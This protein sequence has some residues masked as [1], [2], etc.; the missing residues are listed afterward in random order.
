MSTSAIVLGCIF[1]GVATL[2]ALYVPYAITSALRFRRSAVFGL[3][4]VV[5]MEELPGDDGW[6]AHIRYEIGGVAHTLRVGS[7]GGYALGERVPLR[8]AR[9]EPSRAHL[10]QGHLW[11]ETLGALL[12]ALV[13]GAVAAGL[14]A[15]GHLGV[16]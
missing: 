3:G 14:F 11:L 1:G 8:V 2:A 13:F 6:V 12:L 9:E 10:E 15:L 4:T 5:E 16:L 7:N